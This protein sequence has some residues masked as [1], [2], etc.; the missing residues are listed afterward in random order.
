MA[1][2][3]CSSCEAF[4]DTD[5]DEFAAVDIHFLCW[6]CLDNEDDEGCGI[7]QEELDQNNG[8]N[9]GNK[10]QRAKQKRPSCK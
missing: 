7:T 2:V 8:V 1:L 3:S 10:K 9:N 6:N 5:E 4:I